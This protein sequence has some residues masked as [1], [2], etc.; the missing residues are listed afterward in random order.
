MTGA[1]R[2]TLLDAVREPVGP[3][4]DGMAL[5]LLPPFDVGPGTD[6]D[7]C[8]VAQLRST[9]H[10]YHHGHPVT[11]DIEARAYGNTGYMIWL[12]VPDTPD[13]QS[14]R[15]IPFNGRSSQPATFT[16]AVVMAADALTRLHALLHLVAT[17]AP[18]DLIAAAAG[19]DPLAR[20]IALG[21]RAAGEEVRVAA[22]L[23]PGPGSLD[24]EE[25]ALLAFL[26][27]RSLVSVRGH[28]QPTF[29]EPRYAQA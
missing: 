11:L 26:T 14:A 9:C 7:Y 16:A 2:G 21:H 25:E 29:V 13:P 23:D 15:L 5:D 12:R 4:P 10:R 17:T 8:V 24:S 22:Y 1:A 18:A 3:L 28:E 20:M 27:G 19:R 6:L